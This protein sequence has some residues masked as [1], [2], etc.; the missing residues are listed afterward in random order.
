MGEQ[1]LF[2]T[3]TD[4]WELID[5]AQV[6]SYQPIL[7]RLGRALDAHLARVGD[8]GLLDERDLKEQLAPGG[9]V[10]T[11]PTPTLSVNNQVLTASAE[12]N[13]SIVWRLPGGRWR[14]VTGPLPLEPGMEFKAVRYGWLE[15]SIV[16]YTPGN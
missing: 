16:R 15:S 11:T 8:S 10:P 2:D 3:E 6:P 9:E 12:D 5:L 13:A 1:R 4:P 14:L 7:R